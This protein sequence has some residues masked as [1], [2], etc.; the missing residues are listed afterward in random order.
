MEVDDFM[1]GK[2]GCGSAVGVDTICRTGQLCDFCLTEYG[3]IKC[4]QAENERLKE[5]W[6]ELNTHINELLAEKIDNEFG[7]GMDL[8]FILIR[9]EIKKLEKDGE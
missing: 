5:R 8:G 2:E 4:L 1:A 7:R 9:D 3:Y 6:E